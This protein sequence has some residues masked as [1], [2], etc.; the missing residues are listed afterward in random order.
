MQW[1]ENIR[2][3]YKITML[4]ILAVAA[5]LLVGAS[6]ARY[7]Y[8]AETA[9]DA[10]YSNKMKSVE[11]L[12]DCSIAVRAIQA[13][14]LENNMLDLEKDKKQVDINAEAVAQY[15]KEYDASWQ[16]YLESSGGGDPKAIEADKKWK[17][18]QKVLDD[19]AALVAKGDQAAASAMYGEKAIP[20]VIDWDADMVSMRQAAKDDAKNIA[21]ETEGSVATSGITLLIILIISLLIMSVWSTLIIRSIQKPLTKM[22][23]VCQQFAA[24]DF[25]KTLL[26][27]ERGDE[28]GE[29]AR[30]L[31]SLRKTLGS[32]LTNLSK[33]ATDLAASSEELTA[34]STQTAHAATQVTTAVIKST[35]AASEQ[36]TNLEENMQA[37]KDI[38]TVML[39]LRDDAIKVA[40]HANH[41]SRQAVEGVSAIQKSVAQ[42]ND[43]A[44][45]VAN[46]T[47]VVDRLGQ[48][49]QEIGKIVETIAGISNQ[50]N[51]LAL[52]AAIEAARAGEAGRG[53]SVVAEEVR[54]LAEQSQVA[55]GQIADLIRSVQEETEN[56][57][58][59]MQ[60]GNEAV[61]TGTKSVSALS[62][63]FREIQT[64]VDSVTAEVQKIAH[65][66]DRVTNDVEGISEKFESIYASGKDIAN[67]MQG[68]SAIA[69]EQT[70]AAEEIASASDTLSNFAQDMQESVR[71]FKY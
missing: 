58:V 37:A 7:L 20:L 3:P 55:A 23:S 10:L 48:R 8:Q 71:H 32:I 54:K 17:D 41:A 49:S 9:V 60:E 68:V 24:G 50:T 31:V 16:A 14:L 40:E 44:H 33:Q 69:E 22:V 46:S 45:M 66:I 5:I 65:S 47:A 6:G 64:Y 12:Y 18:F 34:S 61:S 59:S 35:E 27:V 11:H 70:A 52:N 13:R 28:F 56:A 25:R 43:V 39:G 4:V 67:E 42:I 51:L 57:V 36:G 26:R 15:K 38:S 30:A 29:V 19:M 53:F 21:L 1:L 2:T 63:N 62:D